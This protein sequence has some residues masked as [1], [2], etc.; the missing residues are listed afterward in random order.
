M[1]KSFRSLMR[2]DIGFDPTGVVVMRL[3]GG[4][5]TQA[6]RFRRAELVQRVAALPGIES[7]ALHNCAPFASDCGIMPIQKLD[8]KPV[9]RGA[10]PPVEA[11][12]MTEGY[13]R[14]LRIP[15]RSGRALDAR[16]GVS[17][18]PTAVLVNET[19]ARLLWRGE[20]ALGH[21]IVLAGNEDPG[22]E[23]VGVVADVKY[24]AIDAPSRPAVYI[25][26]NQM[27]RFGGS[28][29]LARGRGSVDPIPAIR[30]AVTETDPAVATYAAMTGTGLVG[31]AASSTKFVT[32]L[33][34]G[35]GMGAAMLAALGVYGVLA[36]LVSQRRR[37]FG[38]RMAIG[39]QPRSVLALVVR[40]GAALTAI[41]LVIGVAGALAATRLLRT[42]LFGV[43]PSDWA[44]YVV[45]SMVVGAAGLLAALIPAHRA[46]RVDPVTALRE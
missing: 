19:A 12:I 25:S 40:Q 27:P 43:A 14:T 33:L 39:A 21:R 30:R 16:E 7:V 31:R 37:E 24:E 34:V 17:P 10:I 2:S 6:S 26:G 11:H 4:D 9:E 8:G 29:L 44:T 20:S 5:T 42:F 23:V 22:A 35:F 32:I 46:T 45:I 13:L 28:V 3:S 1:V 38:V 18:S 41:G 36:Y 15:V